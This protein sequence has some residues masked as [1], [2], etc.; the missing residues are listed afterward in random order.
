MNLKHRKT[1]TAVFLICIIFIA[2]TSVLFP[3]FVG[4]DDDDGDFDICSMKGWWW[5]FLRWLLGI[6]CKRKEEST[7]WMSYEDN[8]LGSNISIVGLEYELLWFNG[9]WVVFGSGTTGSDGMIIVNLPIGFDSASQNYKI[10]FLNEW[11][12]IGEITQSAGS[13]VSEIE[14]AVPEI[15]V[16]VNWDDDSDAVGIDIEVY[17]DSILVGT[18]TTDVSGLIVFSIMAGLLEFT[19]LRIADTIVLANQTSVSIQVVVVR[20]LVVDSTTSLPILHKKGLSIV[21]PLQFVVFQLEYPSDIL[22]EKA[23]DYNKSV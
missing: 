17:H 21:L 4:A 14:L 8:L 10:R 3:L 20:E 19:A 13:Y 7:I 2:Q 5:R 22:L 23:L 16:E 9:G 12:H 11:S 18:L 6:D 1:A 15:T